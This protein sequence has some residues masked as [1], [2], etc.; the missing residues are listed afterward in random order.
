M[1]NVN[2]YTAEAK[3]TDVLEKI[4]EKQKE[5]MDLYWTKPVGED[6]D[7]LKGSQEIRRYSKYAV[8]ELAEAYES[9]RD[10][11]YVLDI[12]TH[13]ELIDSIHFYVE[14]LLISNLTYKKILYYLWFWSSEEFW[15]HVNACEKDNKESVETSLW[16]AT[17][18]INIP[19]NRLRNKEWKNEQLPTNRDMFYKENAIWFLN[20]IISLNHLGLDQNLLWEYYSRKNKVNHFRINSNY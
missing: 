2:T 16:N 12:H 5:L 17:Y 18:R 4:F 13:E 7:T 14:K 20:Y 10:H 15:L 3:P 9:Y 11:N 19:D 1:V 8:E 6:I